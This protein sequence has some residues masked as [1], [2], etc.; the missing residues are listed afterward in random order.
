[1]VLLEATP[2]AWKGRAALSETARREVLEALGEDG[3]GY[4]V[5]FGHPRI[6]DQLGVGGA[7]AWSSEAVM[8]RAA[9]RWLDG[10]VG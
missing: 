6:L 8:E 10:R 3:T 5:L 4:L 7:C 9:A 2:R 1:V